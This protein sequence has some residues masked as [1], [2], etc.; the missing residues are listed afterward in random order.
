MKSGKPWRLAAMGPA[1]AAGLCIFA[2][3]SGSAAGVQP[4]I[5]GVSS[6]RLAMHGL[7]LLPANRPP[8]ITEQRALTLTRSSVGR[9][10]L[11][12]PLVRQVLLARVV[13]TAPPLDCLCWIVS[14]DPSGFQPLLP[15]PGAAKPNVNFYVA[16]IDATGGRWLFTEAGN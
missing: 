8:A 5:V 12:A 15:F 13:R 2:A 14:L 16:Y 9:D 6:E 7:Q 1:V 3:T 11:G 4:A 10:F